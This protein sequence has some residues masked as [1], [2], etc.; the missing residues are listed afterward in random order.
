VAT[1]HHLHDAFTP[2]RDMFLH[3]LEDETTALAADAIIDDDAA[4][5]IQLLWSYVCP[6]TLSHS[7]T[8]FNP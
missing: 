4:A 7:S 1:A 3:G 8:H 6:L 2:S 5:A